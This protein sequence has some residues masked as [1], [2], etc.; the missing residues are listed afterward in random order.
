MKLIAEQEKFVELFSTMNMSGLFNPI[1][2]AISK[3]IISMNGRDEADTTLTVQRYKN[4][5]IEDENT[6]KIVFD[7]T[8][9]ING[10]KLFK[11]NE[12]ISI[13]ILENTIV[14]A[15][16]ESA[17]I[18]DVLTI[19]QIDISDVKTPEFPFKIVKGLPQ[20]TNKATKEPLVFDINTTIPIKYLVELVKRANFTEIS[21]KIYK[22]VIK[23]GE[24]KATVGE[25]NSFQKSVSSTIKIEHEGSGELL[26]GAG[27]EEMISTLSGD[28]AINATEGAPVWFTS[29]SDKNVVYTLIAPAMEIE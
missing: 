21:P 26:F 8:E 23:D 2:L 22:I 3:N 1:V 9:M 5:T 18:N 6:A 4:I 27:F 15:N 7:P 24:L 29:K 20:I 10:F 25:E 11:P 12:V 19:P 28:V 17:E 16:V 14:V 13:S